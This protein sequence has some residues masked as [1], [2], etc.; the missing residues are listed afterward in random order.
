MITNNYFTH[1]RIKED[2]PTFDD[3]IDVVV[4]AYRDR[5]LDIFL[6]NDEVVTV[7]NY[8]FT[9]TKEGINRA[10]TSKY[11]QFINFINSLYIE[12]FAIEKFSDTKRLKSGA[13]AV[14]GNGE[15][16]IFSNRCGVDDALWF[17]YNDCHSTII[18]FI[19]LK[20]ATV[21]QKRGKQ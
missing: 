16:V 9:G 17:E 4:K 5:L 20:G 14:L 13:K 10:D 21:T 18:P 7:F 1:F 3:L 12:T 19:A 2:K 15:E 6:M 8:D 11:Y